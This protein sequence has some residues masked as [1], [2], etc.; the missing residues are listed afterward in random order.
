V[1]RVRTSLIGNNRDRGGT[2][3]RQPPRPLG[4]YKEPERYDLTLRAVGRDG[5]PAPF[6]DVGVMNVDDGELFQDFVFLGEDASVTLRV[7]PGHYHVVGFVTGGNFDTL[8]MVG[9]PEVQVTGDATVTLDARLALP[10]RTGVEGVSTRATGVD[11]GYTRLD[12]TGRYG[13]A[14]SWGVGPEAA[15]S[16][17]FAQP[18][19]PVGHGQFEVEVRTRRIPAAAAAPATSP[20]LYDLLFYG[21]QVPDP[22]AWVVS[23]AEAARLP[24]SVGHYRALNDRADYSEVRIGFAPLQ[25]FA[26]GSFDAIAV[27]RVRAEYL[28]P[29]PILW[30]QDAS[31]YNQGAFIDWLGPFRTYAPG[32]RVDERWFGA[33]LRADA[34]GER[35]RLS[36]FVGVADFE[37]TGLHNG[38]VF[39]FDEPGPFR[40]ALRLYRNGRLLAS[41]TTEPFLQTPVRP[42]G[43]S[44]R[45]ERDL[46]GHR[47]LAM[48]DRSRTR[49]WFDAP[50]PTEQFATLPLLEVDYDA[51]LGGR[52][53]AVAGR[54]VTVDLAV[55]RSEGAADSQ[56][57]AT[58]L[59]FSTD[60]GASWTKVLL[61]RLGPGRY[62]GVLPGGRLT[63]GSFVSLRAWA[64]DAS[65]GRIHQD[66]I[67]AFPV[68]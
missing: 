43:A 59:W 64:Q 46:D 2:S 34:Y 62:Q 45:L 41:S 47:V 56:V 42:G 32:E 67:R 40:Q 57:V 1:R 22:P 48:A 58:F 12:A 33:P 10:V 66:L 13:L 18:T 52:N 8:S 30:V 28:H 49:W 37:D 68:R 9:D 19:D 63:R 4:F 31:W 51:T 44:F 65:N 3:G 7:A 16:G 55:H 26:G 27:P 39:A 38:Y 61:R 6:T 25:F 21:P 15:E 23:A 53:G 54:P 50:A 60:D 5:R 24:L 17:L 29:E 14:A 36:M 35:T 11:L 20:L